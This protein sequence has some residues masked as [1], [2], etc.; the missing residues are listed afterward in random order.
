MLYLHSVTELIN[1]FLKAGEG[2]RQLLS[3]STLTGFKNADP[4]QLLAS[5]TT[6]PLI[7]IAENLSLS[8]LAKRALK[9][10]RNLSALAFTVRLLVQ[11]S[12]R[13]GFVED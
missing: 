8:T 9:V 4:L 6:D 1:D 12:S 3:H 10:V 2:F 13:H 11:V 5:A 7:R